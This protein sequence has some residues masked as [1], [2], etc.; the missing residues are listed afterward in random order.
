MNAPRSSRSPK[1]VPPILSRS[2]AWSLERIAKLTAAEVRQLM[3]N[4]QRLGEEEVAKLCE[5]ALKEK[6]HAP[7]PVA[8]TKPAPKK[9]PVRK[10][11]P[12]A[13]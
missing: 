8:A 13:A 3:E 6:L 4:A 2:T 9:K 7:K 12:E 1:Y 11:V 5:K 10:P